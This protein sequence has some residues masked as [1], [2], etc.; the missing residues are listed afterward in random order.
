MNALKVLE[1]KIAAL[2]SVV[3]DLV[4]QNQVLG[5]DNKKLAAEKK[6]LEIQN[7]ELAAECMK[8]THELAQTEAK[9]NA[10]EDSIVH[11]NE[12]ID[13]LNR[14]RSLTRTMVDDLIKSIDLLVSHENQ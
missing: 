13:E 4:S 9:L 5:A 12:K 8:L 10:V 3:N 6:L 14:E 2:A 1:E 7:N 11:G